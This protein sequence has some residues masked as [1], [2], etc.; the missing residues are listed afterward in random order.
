MDVGE[1]LQRTAENP[2]QAAAL[3]NHWIALND[4]HPGLHAIMFNYAVTLADAGDL[5][6]AAFALRAVI[7]RMPGFAPAY[8][9]LGGVLERL[10]LRDQA[11]A[12]WSDLATAPAPFTGENL[13]YKVL[14]LKQMGRVLE[15]AN[16]DGPAEHALR[17]SLELNPEQPDAIQHVLAL[18]QRQCA[19]P[20]LAGNERLPVR[21]LVAG[22]SPLSAGCLTDDPVF[23]LANAANYCRQSIGMPPAPPAVARAPSGRRPRIG[24]VSSDLRDH[25]VGFAMTDVIETHDRDKF[26]I[27]AYDCGIATADCTRARIKAATEH[28]T[29]LN[30]LDDVQAYERIRQD[31]IDILVDLNGYT[32]DAR[33]KVFAMRPAPIAVNWF[34]F[35]GTMGSPYHHYLLADE[36]IVPASHEHYYS[37][38]V[39]RLPCYQPNDRKRPV[40]AIP[41]RAQAGLPEDAF[42]FC[43]LNGMQKIT[44]LTFQRWTI[45]LRHVPNSVLW[46]LTGTD[47]ANARL[48]AKA[49]ELGVAPER[50]IFADKRPNPEHLARYPLADL[51]LDTFPYGAHT[52]AADS[53]WMGVPILT[54]R[55]RGFAARVCASLVHAAGLPEMVCTTPNDYVVRAIGLGNDRA[56]L[57]ALRERLVAGR[58]TCTLFDTPR[59]V[60][61]L[62]ARYDEM[63][64]SP[65]PMPDLRNLD[66]YRDTAMDNDLPAMELLDD[67]GYAEHYRAKLAAFDAVF[68]VQPDNRLWAAV[69]APGYSR[70]ALG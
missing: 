36:H 63:L 16:A 27:F 50:L 58:D 31:G 52:T 43:C 59:L 40:G 65:I 68:P 15:A 28:W 7:A 5:P 66:V 46:L 47:E 60:R 70:S 12:V 26:E 14:A 62:E 29:D 54:L 19:W 57:K 23:H 21:K 38:Q 61:A 41:T 45:V 30:P 9:N 51:F 6:G 1:L 33:T 11:V 37:E 20:V 4:G 18:R 13:N 56:R 22:V 53:L 3:Y 24:Y 25:A 49:A 35:P 48:R 67:A 8:I 32:K 39:L 55:G 64:R 44:A 17:Q 34:G 42:V 2:A 10:G 69:T